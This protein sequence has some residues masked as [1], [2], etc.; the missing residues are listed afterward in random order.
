MCTWA[1]MR[2]CVVSFFLPPLYGFRLVSHSGARLAQH[3]AFTSWAI[4]GF[5]LAILLPQPPSGGTTGMCHHTWLWLFALFCLLFGTEG[6][7]QGFMHVWHNRATPYPW[8]WEPGWQVW[9]SSLFCT[10]QFW[11]GFY[12]KRHR[13]WLMSQREICIFSV[14]WNLL[15]T[16]YRWGSE[17]HQ[18]LKLKFQANEL[19]LEG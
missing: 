2:T 10:F 7:T 1:G 3:M 4:S 19:I 9:S 11:F 13:S 16:V 5:K 8:F 15:V 12:S 14:E 17:K 6:G 18:L